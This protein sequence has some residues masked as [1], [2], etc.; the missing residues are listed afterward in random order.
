MENLNKQEQWVLPLDDTVVFPK[1]KAKIAISDTDSVNIKTL[2]HNKNNYII[3]LAV[4]NEN[5]SGKYK[6]SDFFKIGTLL[7]IDSIQESESGYVVHV[8]GVKRISIDHLYINENDLSAKFTYL[9]ELDDLEA[10]NELNIKEFVKK[11]VLELST[12]FRGSGEFVKAINQMESLDNI[13]AALL[14]FM[15]LSISDRQRLLEQNSRQKMSILFMDLL[16]KQKEKIDLQIDLSNKVNDK[17]NK[18]T[19]KHYYGNS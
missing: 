18:R 16:V 13:I 14:P 1:M 6:K 7:K 15:Q 8:M 19:G 9:T 4:K 12:R 11:H 10:S 3:G 2:V 5:S 17:I